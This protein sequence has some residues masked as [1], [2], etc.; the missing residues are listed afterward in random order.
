MALQLYTIE[1]K[2]DVNEE[3]HDALVQIV[4]QYARD[5]L[6]S[7]ALLA[8]ERKPLVVAR[9]TDAFYSTTEIEMRDPSEDI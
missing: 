4:Q 1:M 9:T 7:G 3:Q 2:C 5:L 6:A 8:G